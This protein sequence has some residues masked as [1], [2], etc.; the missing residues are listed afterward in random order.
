MTRVR[1]SR[2]FWIGAAA[3]LVAAALVAIA[4]V[5]RGEFSDTDGRILVTLGAVLYAGA[6]AISGLALVER[7]RAGSLGWGLVG[8]SAV[9]LTLVLWA[10]WSF[11]F[12][13][14]NDPQDK[15]AWSSVL[16]EL[17][18][19]VAVTSLLLARAPRL[20]ALAAVAGCLVGAAATLSIVGIWTE[21]EGDAFVKAMAAL[22]ILAVLAYF[23]VPVLQRLVGAGGP[24]KV[25]VLA[26]VDG[27]QVVASRGRVEGV[28]VEAPL[29]GERIVLRRRA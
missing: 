28:L 6:G 11:V 5:L 1:L 15:L 10:V 25:R 3:I 22:W 19:L 29:R 12:E 16:V 21:P 9:S 4:A 14:E 13:Q 20:V 7:G 26:E 2:I 27:V 23:L 24:A 17:A 18:G 8:A